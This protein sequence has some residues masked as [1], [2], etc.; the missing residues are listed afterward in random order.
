MC[1]F[2]AAAQDRAASGCVARGQ[3]HGTA[4]VKLEQMRGGAGRWRL[5]GAPVHGSGCKDASQ[6]MQARCAC[7]LAK[8]PS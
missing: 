3:A 4:L 2:G 6:L 5:A 7:L 8:R 1:L